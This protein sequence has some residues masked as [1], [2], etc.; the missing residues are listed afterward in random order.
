MDKLEAK[1]QLLLLEELPTWKKDNP[2]VLRGYRPLT[3]S[4]VECFKGLAE[5]HN[6]TVNIY[7]HLL[8][9]VF[10]SHTCF[11]TRFIRGTTQQH[12]KILSYFRRFSLACSHAWVP[13]R[14][15]IPSYTIRKRFM[16]SC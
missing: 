1:R 3:N 12:T 11:S 15:F 4:Y 6:Q 13:Q 7:S 16:I 10:S 2:Y 9:L 14:H 5:L 8:G